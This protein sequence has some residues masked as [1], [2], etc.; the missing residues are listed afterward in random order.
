MYRPSN[1]SIISLPTFVRCDNLFDVFRAKFYL[2]V[3]SSTKALM[4]AW[5]LAC[6]STSH[7]KIVIPKGT[8]ALGEVNIRGPCKAPVEIQLQGT[9]RAPA[10]LGRFK[11]DSWV[12]FRY[13]D[14]FTLSGGGVFDGQGKTAWKQ[15]DCHKNKNCDK[16]PM[17]SCTLEKKSSNDPKLLT[18][19]I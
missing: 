12:S 3:L 7:S 15:N 13:I 8:F 1:C 11:T 2:L 18:I 10:E 4:S 16:I 14:Q 19:W 9:L 5:K 17:V 6:A